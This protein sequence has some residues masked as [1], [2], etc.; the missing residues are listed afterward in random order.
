LCRLKAFIEDIE[1]EK[2]ESEEYQYI[3]DLTKEKLV[4]LQKS[5]QII[6]LF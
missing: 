2:I 5:K 3:L 6:K 1:N 4:E